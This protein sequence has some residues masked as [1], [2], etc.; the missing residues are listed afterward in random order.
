MN[1]LLARET[2]ICVGPGRWGTSNPDLGVHIDYGDIYNS[3][4][5]VELT[6]QGFG[7][8]PEPSLGTHFFQDL[9]ESQI[10]PL[11]INLDD[12]R[13]ILNRAF[14]YDSP[15]HLLSFLPEEERV[16]NCLRV[17]KV[18]DFRKES[19]LTLAMDDEKSKA[20]AYFTTDSQSV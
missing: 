17:I 2:F 6:G 16:E 7:H 18:S 4:A 1:D 3:R 11:A 20:A 5:L 10:Y 15:N 13:S 12:D 19:R 9:L 8:A 14:F